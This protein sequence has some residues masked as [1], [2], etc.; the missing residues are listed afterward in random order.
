MTKIEKNIFLILYR[1]FSGRHKIVANVRGMECWGVR[2]R[3]TINRYETLP[4]SEALGLQIK[5][6]YFILLVVRC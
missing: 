3:F 5:P 1:Y 4:A 2:G 6:Q